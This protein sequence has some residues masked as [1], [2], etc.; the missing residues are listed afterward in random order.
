M[1]NKFLNFFFVMFDHF[2]YILNRIWCQVKNKFFF[3]SPLFRSTQWIF[4]MLWLNVIIF[5]VLYFN[6]DETKEE[7]QQKI[8]ITHFDRDQ[9]TWMC[10][11]NRFAIQR[12]QHIDKFLNIYSFQYIEMSQWSMLHDKFHRAQKINIDF[13]I[14][15]KSRIS[16]SSYL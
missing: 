12:F 1:E 7:T 11:M 6:C 9:F 13:S 8:K 15:K 2:I 4:P 10:E 3:L 5:C 16:C 14:E